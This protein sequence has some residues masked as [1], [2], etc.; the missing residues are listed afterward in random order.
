MGRLL[1]HGGTFCLK[2]AGVAGQNVSRDRI[3]RSYALT[4]GESEA[5]YLLSADEAFWHGETQQNK[6]YFTCC[7]IVVA[8]VINDMSKI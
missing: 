2:F 7:F 4:W 6:T 3:Y 1:C 5:D 8:H